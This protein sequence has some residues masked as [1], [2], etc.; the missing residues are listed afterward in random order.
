MYITIFPIYGCAV[1]VSYTDSFIR[2]EEPISNNLH[3]LQL[4][5]FFVGITFGWSTNL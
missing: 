3:Q 1:G 5:F 4:L 2:G